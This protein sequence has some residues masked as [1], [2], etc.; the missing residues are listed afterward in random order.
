MCLLG[1][2]LWSKRDTPHIARMSLQNETP[3]G[4][5]RRSNAR[6]RELVD[7]MMATIRAAANIDLWTPDERER[8]EADMARIMSTVRDQ[9]LDRRARLD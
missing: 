5:E 8:Y 9:A 7:E 2:I 1:D 6:L 3:K 4:T